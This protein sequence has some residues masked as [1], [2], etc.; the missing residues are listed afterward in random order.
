MVKVVGV[1]YDNTNKET[2]KQY[3]PLEK[4]YIQFLGKTANLEKDLKYQQEY[5]KQH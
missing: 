3:L 2:L 5:F 4:E 1:D